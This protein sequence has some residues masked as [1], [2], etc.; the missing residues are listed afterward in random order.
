MT[1]VPPA[2]TLS[3]ISSA[4]TTRE[5][6]LDGAGPSASADTVPDHL[7]RI[8]DLIEPPL[9]DAAGLECGLLQAL[10][11]FRRGGELRNLPADALL[12]RDFFQFVVDPLN[13]NR[14]LE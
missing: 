7:L 11:L 3:T 12:A 4:W 1:S 13:E 8:H 9:I 5:L 10:A 2:V 14:L 6:L